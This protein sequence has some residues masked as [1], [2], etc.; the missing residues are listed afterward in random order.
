MKIKMLTLLLLVAGIIMISGCVDSEKQPLSSKAQG[1]LY[2][3][4][5]YPYAGFLDHRSPQ[6]PDVPS[7]A[8]F[9]PQTGSDS[10]H[11]LN[12][13][14]SLLDR[15]IQKADTA[16]SRLEA[17]IQRLKAEGKNVSRVEALLEKHK[18]LVEEAKKYRALADKAVA[19]ENNSSVVDSNL[20]DGSSENLEREY[21][22]E[23]QNFMIQANEVM[24][25]IF[26]EL[27]NLMPGNE[28]LNSTSHLRAAGNGMVNLM[29]NF[30]LNLHVEEGEMGVPIFSQDSKLYIKGDYTTEENTKMQGVNLYR[31]NSADVTISGSRKA[32]MLR[33][34]NITLSA[35]GEGYVTFMGNG[36]YSIEDAGGIKKEQNWSQPFFGDGINP[37]EQGPGGSDEYGLDGPGEHGPDGKNQNHDKVSPGKGRDNITAANKVDA[38]KLDIE[39]DKQH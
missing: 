16:S 31:I 7:P 30:T 29:G 21:L 20:E 38:N 15:N 12:D 1:S 32:V 2:R 14:K 6:M 17:G 22:I 8:S 35:D 33:G 27:R 23:S 37:G 24:K 36:T 39:I 25:E 11:D 4:I 13:A 3:N 26:D 18:S 34:K 9:P 10:M 19:E 5:F 28:E